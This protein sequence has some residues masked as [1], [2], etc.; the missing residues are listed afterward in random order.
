MLHFLADY[1]VRG[2][3]PAPAVSAP[4]ASVPDAP[5]TPEEVVHVMV[6]GPPPAQPPSAGYKEGVWALGVQSGGRVYSQLS[7]AV[8]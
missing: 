6:P 4:A 3:P 5:M 7:G 1:Q 2:L 8:H